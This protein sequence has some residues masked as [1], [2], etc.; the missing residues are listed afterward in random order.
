[1]FSDKKDLR[2]ETNDLIYDF[3][4]YI[5]TLE[6]TVDS[7]NVELDKILINMNMEMS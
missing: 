2:E 6:K 3:K 4:V 5:I 7:L 1:M